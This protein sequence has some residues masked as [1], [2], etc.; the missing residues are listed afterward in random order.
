MSIQVSNA[1]KQQLVD[2]DADLAELAKSASLSMSLPA[3]PTRALH[4]ALATLVPDRYLEYIGKTDGAK[5]GTRHPDD[6]SPFIL[7]AFDFL[8][9]EPARAAELAL[10]IADRLANVLSL[11]A[12]QLLF[13]K[14][15][16]EM[17]SM[18]RSLVDTVLR[19][20]PADPVILRVAV[21]VAQRR[22]DGTLDEL[23]TR[24][25]LADRS[26]SAVT[27]VKRSRRASPV[28]TATVRI[29]LVS[30]F[31]VDQLAEFVDLSCRAI[32]ITPD[33]YIAPFNSWTREMLDR[34]SGLRKFEPELVFMQISIDDLAP[35]LAEYLPADELERVGNAAIERLVDAARHFSEWAP[36]VPLVV[37]SFH[38]AFP[39]P[40]GILESRAAPSRSL[41][42]A[43]VNARLATELRALPSSYLLD[44]AAVAASRGAALTDRSKLRHMAAMRLPPQCLAGIADEYAKYV[45]A[46]KRLT[47]KC[48]V[49]DLDNTLWGGVVGEDGKHG[50]RLGHTSPGS[51]F[52]EF[53]H[54]LRSLTSRG[55]LLAVCSKNNEADALEVIRSHESMVLRESDFSAMRINWKPKPE[56]V[57]SIAAELNIGTDSLVFVDD[58]PGERERM[59]QLLPDVLT[60]ELPRD[61]TLYRSTLEALP[62]LQS[63]EITDEDRTRLTTYHTARLRQ[64]TRVKAATLDEYLR[65]LEIAVDIMPCRDERVARVAQL[66]ARTNQINTT[67]R[68][69]GTEDIVGFA[70][71]PNYFLRVLFS[72]DRF[73]DHGLVAVA[74]ARK[75][76]RQWTIDSFL[77]SCRVIGYGIETTMLAHIAGAAH[78]AGAN[79]LVGEFIRTAKNAPAVD[80]FMRHGFSERD[81]T[82]GVQNWHLDLA[83]APDFPD[84]VKVSIDDA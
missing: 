18:R 44:V 77:M 81:A 35:R 42:I 46:H 53:Q 4:M 14:I 12:L 54:F 63:L 58:D 28:S 80:L 23:L 56:N 82:D 48:V 49:L 9:V 17:L 66:F 60:V 39:G 45:A 30:S 31:T 21:Q 20:F 41:W 79:A 52:I 50:I 59:R 84:W 40:F 55:I 65:S 73:G 3:G 70:T 34:D 74:L 13:G 76:S 83:G 16:T 10:G 2:N 68:R 38:S 33:L 15:G 26:P 57:A 61:P 51:E 1:L 67:T 22:D 11:Q 24:L 64:E 75:E 6:F 36:T 37:H 47:R 7:Q 25:G 27:F 29:A 69:Y 8:D 71:D 32:G 62:Q 72:R 78:A 5:T 43:E 19:R